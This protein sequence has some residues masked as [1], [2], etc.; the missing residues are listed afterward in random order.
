M[1]EQPKATLLPYATVKKIMQSALPEGQRVG[2]DAIE[3]MNTTVVGIIVDYTKK[4][5]AIATNAKRKTVNA[6]DIALSFE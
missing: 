5:G 3:A 1:V 2:K 4:S 6:G